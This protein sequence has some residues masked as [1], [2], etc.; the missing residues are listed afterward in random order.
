MGERCASPWM[1]H[2]AVA[3]DVRTHDVAVRLLPCVRRRNAS[4]IC[5]EAAAPY[6]RLA[7][8]RIHK[9]AMPCWCCVLPVAERVFIVLCRVPRG[10]LQA[11]KSDRSTHGVMWCIVDV[12]M[13][14]L[15]VVFC[16]CA[17]VRRA[18]AC[19]R[20]YLPVASVS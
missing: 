13:C 9:S 6:W 12:V 11:R 8:R 3:S 18:C 4:A 19:T 10:K 7:A 2:T 1:C 16:L 17:R 20:R 5:I 15:H 14:E